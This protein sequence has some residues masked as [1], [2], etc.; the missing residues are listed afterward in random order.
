MNYIV[1]KDCIFCN[2]IAMSHGVNKLIA[3]DLLGFQRHCN[4]IVL[5]SWTT[6]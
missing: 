6:E 4:N 2:F 5:I 1:I 3:I